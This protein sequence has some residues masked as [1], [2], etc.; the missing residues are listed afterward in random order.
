MYYE[1]GKDG[2]LV[3]DFLLPDQI[4]KTISFP[5]LTANF[6]LDYLLLKLLAVWGQKSLL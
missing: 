1:S 5:F 4:F 3:P 6:E 2:C